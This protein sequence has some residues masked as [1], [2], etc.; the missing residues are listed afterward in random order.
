MRLGLRWWPALG[1][2]PRPRSLELPKLHA[3]L[4]GDVPGFDLHARVLM[5]QPAGHFGTA[6]TLGVGPGLMAQVGPA[7]SR[8]PSLV[9]LL[10]PEVGVLARSYRPT[11]AYLGWSA[12]LGYDA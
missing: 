12:P 7:Y 4:V 8:M 10:L 3:L 6:F 5:G 11:R 2:F 9:G 1:W